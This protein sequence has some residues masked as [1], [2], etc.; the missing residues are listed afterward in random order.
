MTNRK[1]LFAILVVCDIILIAA[2]AWWFWPRAAAEA[3]DFDGSRALA[4]AE[5]QMA[6]GPRPT[7]AEA[8]RQTGD[9][10]LAELTA[11]GWKTETQEFVYRDAPARNII[12]KAAIG[13]GPVIII[14]AHYDTRR[15]ADRDSASPT[16]PTP[17]ANDGASGVAVLL[18]LARALDTQDSRY[19]IWLAFFDAEDNGGIDGW[20]WIVGSTH[21]AQTLTV[22]PE[23]VIIA[24]MIG[25][26]DQ[27]LFFETNSDAALSAQLFQI[28]A[29]LGYGEQFIPAPKYAI[30]DDHAPFAQLG[31]PVV[32]LIDFDY[33]HWHTTAD[34]LDKISADSLERVGRVIETFI[35]QNP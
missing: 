19:E 26:A 18:E 14:G 24:D 25:D 6:F 8:H 21:M 3:I 33:P 15:H 31:I 22:R 9:Y 30:L 5:A 17:G 2:G 7:G 28:A 34:T 23:A 11:R 10:I 13:R 32:D 29:A 16:A 12:G 35:E 20:E 4:H 27:Q 1:T